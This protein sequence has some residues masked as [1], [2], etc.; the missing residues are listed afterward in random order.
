MGLFKPG[1]N[2]VLNLFL[3]QK[4]QNFLVYVNMLADKWQLV[5]MR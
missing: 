1:R 3:G 4:L 2:M 5:P